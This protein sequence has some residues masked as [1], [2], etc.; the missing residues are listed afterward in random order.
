[1]NFN[2]ALQRLQLTEYED[3]IINSNS[4]GELH[5]LLDYINLAQVVKDE[6]VLKVKEHFEKC[7]KF[8]EDTW[9]RPESVFQHLDKIF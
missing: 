4:H 5:H 3:R 9:D 2:E 1:M 8:A 7:V 6:H